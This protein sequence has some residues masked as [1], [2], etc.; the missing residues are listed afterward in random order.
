M[1]DTQSVGGPIRVFLLDD[2]EL[3]RRGVRDVLETAPHIE[4]VGEAGTA[5]EALRVVPEIAPDVAVLDI[6]LPDGDGVSVCRDLRSKLPDIACLMLTCLSDDEALFEAIMAGAAGYVLKQI[7][8][9]DLS[10]AIE[11]VA[12]GNSMIDPSTTAHVMERLRSGDRGAAGVDELTE[13]GRRS[14]ALIGGGLTNRQFGVR[15]YLAEKTVK[16]YVSNLLSKLGMQRRTQ[17]A[18]LASKLR[19]TG[20]PYDQR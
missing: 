3:V 12:G 20:K 1:D 9:A 16:N 15:L 2:H 18:V 17:A 4:V 6:R 5:E 14:L 19:Q 13:Q 11:T 7:R 10:H 8:G